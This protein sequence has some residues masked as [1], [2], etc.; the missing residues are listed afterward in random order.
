MNFELICSTT[1]RIENSWK[2]QMQL[3]GIELYTVRNPV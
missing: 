2:N 3:D 1:K